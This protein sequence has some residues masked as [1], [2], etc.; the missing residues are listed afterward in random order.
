MKFV[1]KIKRMLASR[2]FRQAA[3]GMVVIFGAELFGLNLNESQVYAILG[4][5]SALIIGTAVEDAGSKM[6]GTHPAQQGKESP[7]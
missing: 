7:L 1:D 4:I 2:K 6:N 3:T 5:V